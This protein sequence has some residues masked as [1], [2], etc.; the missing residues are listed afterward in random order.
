MKG[1]ARSIRAIVTATVALAASAAAA[2]GA[3]PVTVRFA[4]QI[5]SEADYANV[6]VADALG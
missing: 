5:G 3:A 6:W 4:D 2:Q 1:I